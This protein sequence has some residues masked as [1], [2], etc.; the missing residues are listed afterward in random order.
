[1]INQ[2]S[3]EKK[4][5]ECGGPRDYKGQGRCHACY[6]KRWKKKYQEDHVWREN[7]ITKRRNY[8]EQKKKDGTYEDVLR[9]S[10]I[11]NIRRKFGITEEQYL[12]ML[13]RQDGRCAICRLK[14]T[15]RLHVDHCHETKAIRGLLCEKCN[16]GLGMFKDNPEALRRAANY[17]ERPP[18]EPAR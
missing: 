8:I 10:W 16:R 3:Q 9:K 2:C 17:L 6:N 15:V 14:F 1:M 5:V 4:C 13:Q 11:I 18:T 7:K 12:E